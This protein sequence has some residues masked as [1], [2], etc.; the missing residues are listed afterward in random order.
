VGTKSALETY[1]GYEGYA[2]KPL[3]KPT[4][5]EVAELAE[6]FKEVVKLETSL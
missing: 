2:R 3:P 1:F 6:L 5:A 4:K